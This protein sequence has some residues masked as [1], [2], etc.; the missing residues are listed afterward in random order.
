[1][2]A[3]RERNPSVWMGTA[4]APSFPKLPGDGEVDVVVV[5]AGIT[6]LTTA[7][8]L[9]DGGAS[10]AVVEAGRVASGS[11][12]FNTAKVTSLHGLVYAQLLRTLGR[13]KAGQYAAANQAA[14]EQVVALDERL[15]RVSSVERQSAATYTTD[16]SR[17]AEIAAEVEAATSLGLPATYETT[18]ALPYPVAAAVRLADQAQFHPVRYCHAVASAIS[19]AGGA[20][21][22][23][24]RALDIEERDSGVVVRTEHGLIRAGQ[25]VVATLLP[26][27]DVGGFFAKAAPYRSYGMAVKAD[28]EVAEGMY[29]GIDEPTRTVRRLSLDGEQALVVGGHGHKVGQGGDTRQHYAEIE[30][31]ARSAFGARSV[32]YRWSAQDYVTSD[33]V[34]YVGRMPRRSRTFVAC[35][36]RKWGLS[37][38]T[39]AA[40]VL[41]ETLQGRS[42][43]WSVVFDATRVDPRASATSFVKENVDVGRRFVVDRLKKLRAPSVAE[44]EPGEGRIVDLDGRKVA[45]Y[46][47]DSGTVHAVSAT[48]THLGCTV[49]WNPAEASWD[50]PCH[51]SRFS[52]TGRLLDGPA[53]DDLEQVAGPE[54]GGDPG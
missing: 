27:L 45:A 18:T 43:P 4:E 11:S 39:A 17:V 19:G 9:Q 14:I 5:G 13:E 15:G 50:C 35:G 42:S 23:S 54:V 3:A 36:F 21:H 34:P 25:A 24:T 47:D 29:L 6:G 52:A 28:V 10:V 7:L 44:L 46:R 31:W 1:M 32:E 48:C 30:A 49:A 2:G 40:M 20:I 16:Q 22:E 38:G 8:L 33:H 12:G 53:V 41:A 26:F 51:G 37:G